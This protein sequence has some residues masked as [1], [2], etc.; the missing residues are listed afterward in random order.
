MIIMC[1]TY[2]RSGLSP[3]IIF[4]ATIKPKSLQ[5]QHKLTH[6]VPVPPPDMDYTAIIT[7]P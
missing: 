4:Q 6:S 3:R 5:G 2:F 7:V 1:V